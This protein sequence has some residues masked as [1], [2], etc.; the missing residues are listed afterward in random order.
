[1]LAAGF[2]VT[3]ESQTAGDVLGPGDGRAVVSVEIHETAGGVLPDANGVG[4]HHPVV[5]V[6]TGVDI[7]H[8]QNG[9]PHVQTKVGW[10]GIGNFLSSFLNI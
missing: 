8:T 7:S 2:S 4:G 9:E 1:M 3:S 6:F 5:A 10:G